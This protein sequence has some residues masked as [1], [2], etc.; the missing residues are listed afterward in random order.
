MS[1]TFQPPWSHSLTD[2]HSY[3]GIA[4]HYLHSSS[5]PDL[6]ARLGELQF[7][8][9][10]TLQDRL[11]IINSTIEEF[12]TG[13]PHD[14][15][16]SAPVS[17]PIRA[18]ID[19]CF[20]PANDITAVLDALEGMI[21][22]EDTHALKSIISPWAEKTKST[23]LQRSPTSVRVALRQ[24]REGRRW[25]IAETFRN[26]HVIASKFME[27]PDF[28][29]GV[30][31]L[32]IRK[33]KTTPQWKPASLEAV[34]DSEVDSFF[35]ARPSLELL[36]T[37]D[38]GDYPHAWTGLPREQEVQEFVGAK[39]VGVQQVVE[40]FE[41]KTGG[42]M[43]VREKVSEILDRKGDVVDGMVSWKR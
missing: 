42:K 21:Q 31:S 32:L 38:Y 43:G 18:S 2:D 23:I 37:K 20:Q 3:S 30:S 34:S 35:S 27:H 39:R 26:E 22:L 24:L 41:Q 1:T 33:P 25:T 13:L 8:D 17:G 11:Q 10:M 4:T 40:H 28:V 5:L 36:S 29:E 16:I 12:T 19:Y 9:S 14:Q 6:E 7:K 15:P